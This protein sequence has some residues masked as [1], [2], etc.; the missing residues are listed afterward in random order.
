MTHALSVLINKLEVVEIVKIYIK[1]HRKKIGMTQTEL[2]KKSKVSRATIWALETGK[3]TDTT[4]STLTSIADAL[5]VPV[6][7]ILTDDRTA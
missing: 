5:G 7:V 3:Q 1:E 6:D 2:A 4:T